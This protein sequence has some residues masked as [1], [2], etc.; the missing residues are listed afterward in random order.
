VVSPQNGNPIAVP[1]L[2]GHE[3]SDRLQTIVTSIDVISHEQI[4]R[5]GALSSDPKEFDEIIEL[6]VNITTYGDWSLY[7]LDIGFFL[8]HSLGLFDLMK[9][10]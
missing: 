9:L 8:Q 5:V 3:Q 10:R 6:T 4:I 1:N 7:R 2:Q